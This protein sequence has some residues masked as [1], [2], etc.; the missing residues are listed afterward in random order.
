MRTF[1]HQLFAFGQEQQCS[2]MMR[3]QMGRRT[4]SNLYSDLVMRATLRKYCAPISQATGSGEYRIRP[5]ITMWQH[6]ASI[7]LTIGSGD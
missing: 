3:K 6:C 5:V 2:K 1:T 4:K 7:L